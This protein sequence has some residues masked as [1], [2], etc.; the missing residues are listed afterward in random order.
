LQCRPGY[1]Q[2]RRRHGDA[3]LLRRGDLFRDR[4]PTDEGTPASAEA[5][6]FAG[7]R[8]SEG[9]GRLMRPQGDIQPWGRRVSD[10]QGCPGSF[11][12]R[13]GAPHDP[14]VLR[15]QAVWAR[16]FARG[17]SARAAHSRRP[18][19]RCRKRRLGF[20]VARKRRRRGSVAPRTQASVALAAAEGTVWEG[21]CGSR[22]SPGLPREGEQ[23]VPST[24]RPKVG[25]PSE[26]TKSQQPSAVTRGQIAR[27][28]P[29]RRRRSC[30]SRQ[31]AARH[32]EA[33]AVT[34]HPGGVRR[35]WPGV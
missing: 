12:S 15:Q 25:Q 14:A 29:A 20:V 8:G 9:L 6:P 5:P 11:Q 13:G 16:S 4:F 34:L 31:A 7:R 19:N 30:R 32:S 27:G 26:A 22:F 18:T 3:C 2:D 28:V 24:E 23:V 10:N 21:S 17:F 33:P 35:A 1:K